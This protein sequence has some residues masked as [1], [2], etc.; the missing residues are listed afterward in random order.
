MKCKSGRNPALATHSELD[1]KKK[2]NLDIKKT[3][4][5]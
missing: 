4:K 2:T 5:I 1:N 3:N